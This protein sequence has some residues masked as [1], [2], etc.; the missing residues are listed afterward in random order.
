METLQ[1]VLLHSLLK[2]W[3]CHQLRHP[4]EALFGCQVPKLLPPRPSLQRA[5][6]FFGS[7][8]CQL[9]FKLFF[10]LLLLFGRWLAPRSLS[11]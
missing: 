2:Y 4:F 3:I 10:K 1:H 7:H 8:C 5:L 6:F 9:C 11:A